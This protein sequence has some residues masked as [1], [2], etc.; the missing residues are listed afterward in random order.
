MNGFEK[1]TKRAFAKII[2]GFLIA[3]IVDA[4]VSSGLLPNYIAILFGIGSG[5][6]AVELMF[7][8]PSWGTGYLIGWLLG[9]GLLLQSGIM[10]I[11]GLIAY[12]IIPLLFL[13]LRAKA[14][15]DRH[16]IFV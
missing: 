8:Y 9:A 1:G 3:V 14:W 13:I 6:G 7:R 10:G 4:F 2:D 5:I 15:L 12:F 11:S 16:L